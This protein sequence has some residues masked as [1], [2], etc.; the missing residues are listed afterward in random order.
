MLDIIKHQLQNFPLEPKYPDPREGRSSA[1]VMLILHGNP[2]DPQLVLTQRAAHL[3]SHAGEVAYPGGMWEQGDTD[4]LATA[5]RET[6]E[7]IGLPA[8]RL[9]P[10][11]MLPSGSPRTGN[12]TVFPFVGLTDDPLKLTPQPSEIAAI[13]D[14]PISL[15]TDIERYQYFEIDTGA[16]RVELPYFPYK[17]YRIWGFTLH[18][19]VEMLNKTLSADIRLRYPDSAKINRLRQ[20]EKNQKS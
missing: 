17:N 11:A 18:I 5:M 2:S 9:T 7:E 20:R 3:S 8:D 13:F 4:L 14:L 15:L 19:L 1:A 10:I 12:V 16:D 6:E